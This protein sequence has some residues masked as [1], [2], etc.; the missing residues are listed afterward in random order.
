[1]LFLTGLGGG[2]KATLAM[3]DVLRV[4][5]RLETATGTTWEL[6]DEL[7]LTL[8]PALTTTTA[9]TTT[10]A[11]PSSKQGSTPRPTTAGSDGP[12]LGSNV[13]AWSLSWCKEEYWGPTLM[14]TC[15][16]AQDVQVR[17]SLTVP[18]NMRRS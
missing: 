10:S 6:R 3:D 11:L 8:T 16:G 5:E 14:A 4:Y 13:G 9:T 17:V 1:M 7:D 2:L 15:P 12:S 18:V